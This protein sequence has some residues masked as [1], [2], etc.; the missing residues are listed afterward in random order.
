MHIAPAPVWLPEDYDK[1]ALETA[2]EVL[3]DIP[4]CKDAE[5]G[6][7]WVNAAPML[8]I[9]FSNLPEVCEKSELGVAIPAFA[10]RLVA[11]SQSEPMRPGRPLE[12]DELKRA[13]RTNIENYL[14]KHGIRLYPE[15]WFS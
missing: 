11:I 10:Q 2:K 6:I 5:Y 12:G 9:T 14:H 3:A 13:L 1:R 8:W 7:T 4:E 15:N